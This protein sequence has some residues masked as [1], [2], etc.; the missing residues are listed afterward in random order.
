MQFLTE[1]VLQTTLGGVLGVVSGLVLMHAIPMIYQ[2]WQAQVLQ[3]PPIQIEHLPVQAHIPSF[4]LA[5]LMAVGVGIFFGWYPSRRA[6][7][8]DPIEALRHE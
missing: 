8:L 3:L 4:F 2:V 1:A 5:F 7:W 6:A